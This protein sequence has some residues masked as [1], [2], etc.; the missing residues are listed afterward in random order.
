MPDNLISTIVQAENG[1]GRWKMTDAVKANST[2]VAEFNANLTSFSNTV[3]E[4]IVKEMMQKSI[5]IGQERHLKYMTL[6]YFVL[7]VITLKI[8]YQIRSP[9]NKLVTSLLSSIIL[10]HRSKSRNYWL[11]ITIVVA[12]RF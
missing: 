9:L 8:F 2:L 12:V 4:K 10:V 6:T 5:A 3:P 11:L 7:D 1:T